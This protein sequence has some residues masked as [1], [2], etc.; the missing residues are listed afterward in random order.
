MTGAAMRVAV[1]GSGVV[2]AAISWSLADRGAAVT[3]IDPGDSTANTSRGSLA[4]LNVSSTRDETYATFR[5][6][7]LRLWKAIAGRPGCPA[8][9]SGSCLWGQRFEDLAARAAWLSNLGWPARILTGAEFARQQPGI[10]IAPRAVM[11]VPEEGVADPRRV[12]PWLL[13][14]ACALGARTV[15]GRVKEIDRGV[16]LSDGTRLAADAV[17]AAAGAATPDIVAPLGAR[18][19]VDRRP[20][21]LVRTRPAPPLA[22]GY[23]G[24][25]RVN[26]WQDSEGAILAGVEQRGAE[27]PDSPEQLPQWILCELERLYAAPARLSTAEILIRDRPVPADGLPIVGPLP[28][29]P[30]VYVAVTHSGM[31]L[32][33]LIGKLAAAEIMTGRA[34][35]DLSGYRPR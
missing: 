31:T 24:G 7:S 35:P 33:P 8:S 1:V 4:W 19:S 13:E 9:L 27:G 32:A 6:R 5:A 23:I 17:V 16:R 29:M 3:V 18:I 30:N 12:G 34:E 14:Q 26:F 15:R 2:G 28:S 11:H 20:G 22:T 10:A 21:L 25:D